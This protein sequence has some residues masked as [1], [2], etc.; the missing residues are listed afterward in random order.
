MLSQWFLVGAGRCG[1]QL[2]RAMTAAG[3]EVAGVA[4]ALAARAG[5][6]CAGCS[7]AFPTFGP[8]DA[9]PPAHGMLLAVPDSAIPA[10]AEALAPRLHR[11]TSRRPPHLRPAARQ[12]AR[13]RSRANAGAAVG[14]FHPLVSFPTAT[15][16][17]VPPGGRRR[18]RGGRRRARC[19]RRAR[20]ARALGMR[21]VRLRRGC[22]APLP[23]GGRAGGQPDARAGGRGA[24]AA[25]PG[26]S[27]AAAGGGARSAPW[28][29]GSVE[30]A[31]SARGLEKL[32]GPRR[33]RRRRGGRCP[34][35]GAPGRSREPPI[36][37][38]RRSRSQA[39][40]SEGLISEKQAQR[41][42]LSVDQ[43][44]LVC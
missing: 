37:R 13:A 25:R 38:S 35:R 41:A 11:A 23:R 19:A 42:R 33:T 40:P 44:G 8:G 14:S 4:G 34:S 16:A 27:A 18:G 29:T 5:R 1:L 39:S 15:G 6:G 22:Q 43:P 9:L 32:T 2:A 7:P 20:L 31:L 24:R 36:G 30:A 28:S 17:A 21:P 12:R 3:I 10:C 26:R